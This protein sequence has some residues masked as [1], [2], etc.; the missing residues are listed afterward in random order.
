MTDNKI[1][2]SSAPNLL[3]PLPLP[4]DQ[5]HPSSASGFLFVNR[6]ILRG[7]GVNG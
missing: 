3:L 4:T 1:L 2:I 7:S 6:G 5:P